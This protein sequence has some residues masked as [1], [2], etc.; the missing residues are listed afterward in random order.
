MTNKLTIFLV[1]DHTL[2]REGIE[3]LLSNWPEVSNTYT[4]TNGMELLAQLTTVKPD[5]ILMDINMPVM[6]GIKATEEV[7]KL[8]SDAKVIALSMHAE[9]HFYTEMMEAG[10]KG[11]LLKNSEF[12][13]V[14][15]AIKEVHEGRSYFSPEIMKAI[16]R[17]LNKK[18]QVPKPS[19]LSSRETEVLF[20][21][22]KGYSNVEIAE[23]LCISKRTVDKHRENI[24]LKSSSKNTAELVIYAIQN[25]YFHL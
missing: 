19:A 8:Q 5:I 17:N 15:R 10:A 20:H 24:L 4:A 6:D 25:K 7:L 23:L 22:C 1:D 3:F 9:E 18:P 11:F 16:I 14:K 21:I 12:E 2:F 13:D